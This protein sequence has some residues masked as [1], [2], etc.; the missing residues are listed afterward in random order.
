MSLLEQMARLMALIASGRAG[1]PLAVRFLATFGACTAL[2][3]LTVGEQ[4][5]RSEKGMDPKYRPINGGALLGKTV[6][7]TVANTESGLRVARSMTS[8]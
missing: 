4:R 3:K 7:S 8:I 2:N 1:A 6:A 5:A